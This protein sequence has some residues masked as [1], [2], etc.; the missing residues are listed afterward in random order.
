MQPFLDAGELRI[1]EDEA[2]TFI[3]AATGR[4]GN[5]FSQTRLYSNRLRQRRRCR[6]RCAWQWSALLGR[7]NLNRRGRCL[8]HHW[9]RI[10]ERSLCFSERRTAGRRHRHQRWH[11]R[12][13]IEILREAQRYHLRRRK[14]VVMRRRRIP[15]GDYVSNKNGNNNRKGSAAPQ[16]FLPPHARRSPRHDTAL[17]FLSNED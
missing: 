11:T 15:A 5:L 1:I 16:R 4:S 17:Y 12:S 14:L 8:W 9:C 7:R 2:R 13:I 10:Q 3:K 6:R